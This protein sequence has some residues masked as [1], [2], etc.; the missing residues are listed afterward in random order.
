METRRYL[1]DDIQEDLV[2]AVLDTRRAPRDATCN[3]LGDMHLCLVQLLTSC[4][5]TERVRAHVLAT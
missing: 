2:F 3:S 5:N 4:V 1:L